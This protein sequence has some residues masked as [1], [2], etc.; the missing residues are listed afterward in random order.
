MR[1]SS[2]FTLLILAMPLSVSDACGP[3][4]EY[5]GYSF[6]H[7]DIVRAA[8]GY[9][10]YFVSIKDIYSKYVDADKE[11]NNAN[12][13]EWHERFCKVPTK[14]DMTYVIYNASILQLE[15][16]RDIIQSDAVGLS[17]LDRR[18]ATNTF[19]KYLYKNKCIETVDYLIFAKECEPH[20][21][22]KDRW[23]DDGPNV[24]AMMKFIT[25]GKKAFLNTKSYYFRLRYAY[26]LIRLAHY[27]K[28]YKLVLE[29]YDYL[30]PKID[31]DPSIVD[32]W[33]IGH[34]AGALK[35]LGKNAEA[36][37]LFS[38]VF[39]AC[40]SKRESALRSFSIQTDQDWKAC[41]QLCQDEEEEAT[42]YALRA[43]FSK[44]E[45][46][47]ELQEIYKRDPENKFIEPLVVEELFRLEKD[48]L[49]LEFNKER[50]Y[51][52]SDFNIP[53]ADAGKRVVGLQTF[54]R[55]VVEDKKHDRAD[56]WKIMEGYLELLAGDYYFADQSFK[57]AGKIT[58]N[59]TLEDQ[60]SAMRLALKVLNYDHLSEKEEDEIDHIRR[61][62]KV[63]EANKDFDKF[64]LDRLAYLYEAQ[65]DDVKS[66]LCY[67][68]IKDLKPNIDEEMI[69]QLLK[70]SR[71][72]DKSRLERALVMKSDGSTVEPDLLDMKANLYLSQFEMGKALEAYNAMPDETYWDNYGLYYPFV[73]RINDC[74]NCPLP[75][76]VTAENKG[77]VLRQILTLEQ[78][79]IIEPDNDKAARDLFKVGLAWYNSSY[80][81]YNW[82]MM[83]YYR[84]GSGLD[85]SL[86]HGGDPIVP[87][88]NSYSGNRENFDTQKALTYF[89]K[90][91]KMAV[92]PELKAKAAFFA[93][94]CE[95]KQNY[96]KKAKG[97][98]PTAYYFN[99]LN[100]EYK[101][102]EY[103]QT[104][105][106]ECKYFEYFVTN[107]FEEE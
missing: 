69:D 26:Q 25:K 74:V 14:N 32:Y 107:D 81:S 49:G 9:A 33:I 95:Q 83:D 104:I 16:I 38:R 56:L 68:K 85:Y 20:V 27:A 82:R 1:I 91:R 4:I 87:L 2:I 19:A 47:K 77:V 12:I 15:G 6:L 98:I 63:Y 31:A 51:N 35:K 64:I 39:D 71:E 100:F 101:D 46:T 5:Y 53:R 30:M 73:E 48:L 93:A 66:F 36:A 55:Q 106:E 99:M 60:L 92:N 3:S 44:S 65:G 88:W 37:Y 42:L 62:S 90:A 40:P 75:D 41:I 11:R 78:Q 86:G 94:K 58:K 89:E 103:Y 13:N 50:K 61:S 84:S 96:F 79:A 28:K 57:A 105:I 7:P 97:E 70:L 29:L 8:D 80:F 102:T 22:A 52:K 34:K 43:H 72:K 76:T 45:I 18:L 24:K 67:H 23:N 10:P 17:Y 54:V 59:D 21:I